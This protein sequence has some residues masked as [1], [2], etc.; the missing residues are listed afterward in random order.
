M[1]SIEG[2]E[3]FTKLTKLNCYGNYLTNVDLSGNPALVEV[4][5]L[6]RGR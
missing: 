1:T 2:I 4:T 5:V 6:G 3:F